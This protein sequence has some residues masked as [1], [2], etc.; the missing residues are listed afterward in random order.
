MDDYI[1]IE[2]RIITYSNI[3]ILVIENII[4]PESTK[5]ILAYYDN[6]ANKQIAYNTGTKNRLH[7]YP[8]KNLV[9]EIDNR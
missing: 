1:S 8:C 7:V 2:K 6:N 9:I 5:M 4:S 3:L